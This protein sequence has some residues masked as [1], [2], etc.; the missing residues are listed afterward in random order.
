MGKVV[1]ALCVLVPLAVVGV[2]AVRAED[3]PYKTPSADEVR[4]ALRGIPYEVA[5]DEARP[6][7]D[8]NVYSGSIESP[9]QKGSGTLRFVVITGDGASDY[10]DSRPQPLIQGV[11]NIRA[12]G[13]GS[14]GEVVVLD[15]FHGDGPTGPVLAA[16]SEALGEAVASAASD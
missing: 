15:S 9:S 1:A 2:L 8:L 6:S 3:S 11:P 5:F 4:E 13:I 12:G 14:E 16:M 7:D 10:V